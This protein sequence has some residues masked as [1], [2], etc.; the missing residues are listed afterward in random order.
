MEM[1]NTFMLFH[2]CGHSMWQWKEKGL[3]TGCGQGVI[4]KFVKWQPQ[5][6]EGKIITTE[7]D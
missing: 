7:Y 6:K 2:S 4:Q 5:N 3:V 1:A